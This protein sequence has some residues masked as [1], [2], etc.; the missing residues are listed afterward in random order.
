MAQRKITVVVV[1]P[2]KKARIEEISSSLEGMQSKV[3]GFIQ[4]LY[5]FEDNV[6]LI[7]NE[8]GK[9]DGLPHNRALSSQ[10][11]GIY[12]IIS[13]TFFIAGTGKERFVS[14]TEEQQK[15][16]EQMFL[17]PE[18]FSIRNGKIIAIKYDFV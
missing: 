13:G 7:C 8:N 18:K 4:A 10:E 14:L 1:E 12:D 17:F 15:R 11:L 6:A 9:I 2:G 3:G 16:Y 5:P